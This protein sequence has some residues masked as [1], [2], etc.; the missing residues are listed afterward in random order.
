MKNE[1]LPAGQDRQKD[2]DREP[3]QHKREQ[4]FISVNAQVEIE[5]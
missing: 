3:L 4:I 5:G 1:S 2:V